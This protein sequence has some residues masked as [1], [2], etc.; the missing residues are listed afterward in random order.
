MRLAAA[1]VWLA[2]GLYVIGSWLWFRSYI[3][4]LPESAG[5]SRLRRQRAGFLAAGVAALGVGLW[6]LFM[7]LA[8]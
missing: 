6:Q 5:N 1:A 7:F 4:S 8:Q 3:N 2:L